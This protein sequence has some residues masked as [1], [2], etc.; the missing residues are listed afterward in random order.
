MIDITPFQGV[1]P[2]PPSGGCGPA[3]D[4]CGVSTWVELGGAGA[5]DAES[6]GVGTATMRFLRGIPPKGLLDQLIK[7]A[8]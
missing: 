1:G 4:V 3:C 2:A 8:S 5:Q 7:D 6:T